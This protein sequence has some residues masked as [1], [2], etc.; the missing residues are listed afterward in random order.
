MPKLIEY[1]RTTYASAWEL[2]EVV[3]DTGGKCA[4]DTAAR[5]LNRKVSGS[6]KAIIG[7]AVKFGLLTSKRD[8]LTTTTLFRRIKHA[9][10]KAEETVFHREAFLT[11]PLFTQVCRKFRGRELPVQM[12]DVML[13]REFGVEEFNAPAVAKAFAEG[14]R[15][16]G[17]LDEGNV[18]ADIDQLAA[19]QAPR[20]ELSSPA[21][22]PNAFRPAD[23]ERNTTGTA[24]PRISFAPFD[25][26]ESR[27][28]EGTGPPAASDAA[29]PTTGRQS[30]GKTGVQAQRNNPT[31]NP[32]ALSRPHHEQPGDAVESLFALPRGTQ[33]NGDGDGPMSTQPASVGRAASP[34]QTAPY[35]PT[36]RP[37]VNA[38]GAAPTTQRTEQT[39]PPTTSR[40]APAGYQVQ[41]SGPG[42][43]T[44]LTIADEAD[45]DLAQALLE[46]IRRHL[47]QA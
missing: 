6:F 25:T 13:I 32:T 21:P 19:R 45:L 26:Q 42:L 15:A 18:L 5:K 23:D 30:S 29:P 22:A 38:S 47:R 12:L 9:Y 3:D 37:E 40:P 7:S 41:L 4:Q 24:T 39:R 11:P 28:Q 27:E 20:R 16:V 44:T 14:A 17:L 8:L 31:L 1:P 46:K 34:V 35:A 36:Q 10:D 43:N 33:R 2:S